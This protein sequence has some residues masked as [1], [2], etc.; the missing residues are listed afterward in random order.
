[1]VLVLFL[2]SE[3]FILRHYVH[4]IS[5]IRSIWDIFKL[6]YVPA[7]IRNLFLLYALAF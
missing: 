3:Y 2:S 1:M 6:S 5:M 7:R 4:L